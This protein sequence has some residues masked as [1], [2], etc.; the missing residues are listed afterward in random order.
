MK[1]IFYPFITLLLPVFALA[2]AEIPGTGPT[3]IEDL[4]NITKS[5][6]NWVFTFG[7]VIITIMV[8]VGAIAYATSGGDE[9]KSGNAKKTV[10]YSLIGAAIIGL[11]WLLV[12]NIIPAFLGVSSRGTL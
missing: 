4:Y 10:I 12:N 9:T 11:G 6:M 8:I 3:R 5:A 7:L 2:V 1:K